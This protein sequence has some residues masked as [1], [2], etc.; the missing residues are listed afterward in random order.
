MSKE[1][2]P[3]SLPV[4]ANVFVTRIREFKA[5]VITLEPGSTNRPQRRLPTL[6][7]AS[8]VWE[9]M[10]PHPPTPH[11]KSLRPPGH[12]HSRR[13]P[14]S[15][16]TPPPPPPAPPPPLAIGN[17][18]CEASPPPAPALPAAPEP[19]GRSPKLAR[20]SND[21]NS[22]PRPLPPRVKSPSVRTIVISS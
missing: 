17:G 20:K 4:F 18:V 10:P 7:L 5:L 16:R 19:T 9:K 3:Y 13:P 11:P 12:R 15:P 14:H 22:A 6:L 8:C 21:L 2:L 1:Y